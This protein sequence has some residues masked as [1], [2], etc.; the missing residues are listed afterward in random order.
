VATCTLPERSAMREE[1]VTLAQD[2]GAGNRRV[3]ANFVRLI[4]GYMVRAVGVAR[5]ARSSNTGAGLM[6]TRGSME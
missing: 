2:A 4:S 6:L 1:L 5:S 3:T